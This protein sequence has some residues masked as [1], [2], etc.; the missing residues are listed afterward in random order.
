MA[1]KAVE[2]AEDAG[3][4]PSAQASDNEEENKLEYTNIHNE[5]K[6]LVEELIGCLLHR[7]LHR[8]QQLRREIEIDGQRDTEDRIHGE[9]GDN[10]GGRNPPLCVGQE[11]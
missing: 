2:S 7:Y 6:K 8:T 5:F 1:E 10:I 3:F 9:T 11:R 4:P